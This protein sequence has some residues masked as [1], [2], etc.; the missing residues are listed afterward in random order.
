MNVR[1]AKHVV[2]ITDDEISY[3]IVYSVVAVIKY[4]KNM[5]RKPYDYNKIRF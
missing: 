3:S 4:K 5:E 1:Q 2:I